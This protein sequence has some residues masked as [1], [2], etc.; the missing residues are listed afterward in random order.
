ML[1]DNVSVWVQSFIPR[2]L[3]KVGHDDVITDRLFEVLIIKISSLML[4]RVGG[5]K[6]LLDSRSG[7]KNHKILL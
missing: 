4:K 2:V 6:V 1:N 3:K 7:I 5:A